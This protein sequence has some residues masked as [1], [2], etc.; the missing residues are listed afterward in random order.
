MTTAFDS[1]S[2]V[3]VSAGVGELCPTRPLADRI[4]ESVCRSLAARGEMVELE[5][6][7]LRRLATDLARH[8]ARGHVSLDLREAMAA[9]VAADGLV[10]ATPVVD[11]SPSDVFHSFF[12]VLEDGALSGVPVLLAATCRSRRQLPDVGQVVRDHLV[13]SHA[14]PVPTVV[15][16]GAEEWEGSTD[17]VGHLRA[18]I[19]QAAAELAAAMSFSSRLG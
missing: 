14:E 7:E 8:S 17:G 15:V 2:L 18:R 6:V 5:V 10:V 12:D 4:A 9:V 19:D 11:A 13:R 16:A 1:G 3:V